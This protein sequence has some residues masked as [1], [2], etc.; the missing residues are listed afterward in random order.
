MNM[1]K[2]QYKIEIQI[3]ELYFF[4]TFQLQ[5]LHP[6]H[7]KLVFVKTSPADPLLKK[8]CTNK[9]DESILDLKNKILFLHDNSL[10]FVAKFFRG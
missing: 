1:T 8:T 10:S 4:I 9:R 2:L 7:F 3:L 6:I 5:F